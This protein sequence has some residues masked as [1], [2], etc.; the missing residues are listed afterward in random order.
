VEESGAVVGVGIVKWHAARKGESCDEGS[1]DT[2]VRKA[3]AS[4]FD[5]HSEICGDASEYTLFEPYNDLVGAL[6]EATPES[7]KTER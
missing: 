2:L 3:E 7:A 6:D 4:Q 5:M 1:D